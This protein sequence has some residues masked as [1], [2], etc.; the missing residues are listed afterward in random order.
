MFVVYF[1]AAIMSRVY[2][3]DKMRT[4]LLQ[5][6]A[7]APKIDQKIN[8]LQRGRRWDQYLLV[9]AGGKFSLAVQTDFL[10]KK[11][12][13]LFD[14]HQCK[15]TFETHC[16]NYKSLCHQSGKQE[17]SQGGDRENN[18]DQILQQHGPRDDLCQMR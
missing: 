11:K 9:G 18:C 13:V 16:H 8:D 7:A 3:T 5:H 6:S 14:R 12:A 15:S 2:C 1:R 4:T 10:I 17:L